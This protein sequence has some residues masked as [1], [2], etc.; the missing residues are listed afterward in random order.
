MPF[1]H[2]YFTAESEYILSKKLKRTSLPNRHLVKPISPKHRSQVLRGAKRDG[3]PNGNGQRVFILRVQR[4]AGKARWKHARGVEIDD[5][6]VPRLVDGEVLSVDIA[7]V[8]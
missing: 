7:V 6:D 5:P 1:T 4:P 8:A 3:P 2:L